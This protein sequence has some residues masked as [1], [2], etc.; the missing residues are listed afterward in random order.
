GNRSCQDAGTFLESLGR[1]S[2]TVHATLLARLAV[3]VQDTTAAVTGKWTA[4][5]R[6]SRKSIA[7]TWN[8]SSEVLPE[9]ATRD[10]RVNL[11]RAVE[12]AQVFGHHP[13][14]AEAG[15]EPHH[16]RLDAAHPTSWQPVGV[17]LVEERDDLVL[18]QVVQRQRVM[19]VLHRG[20]A[21]R[22]ADRPSALAV[23]ALDPPA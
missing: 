8:G 14:G 10:S 12:S 19:V 7:G 20:I 16:G 13:F 15:N 9:P 2:R 21:L 1:D 23:V 18:E 17:A 5:V 4:S 11:T 22:T 3:G 6:R